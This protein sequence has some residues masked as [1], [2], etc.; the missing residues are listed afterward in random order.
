MRRI[1]GILGHCSGYSSK[2]FL[3]QGVYSRV[4][5]FSG[6]RKGVKKIS[7]SRLP[8]GS[9]TCVPHHTTSGCLGPPREQF[10]ARH[11]N[12]SQNGRGHGNWGSCVGA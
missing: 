1:T 8:V 7:G 2:N 3:V 5:S 11:M 9:R 10:S 4:G 6:S 12:Q